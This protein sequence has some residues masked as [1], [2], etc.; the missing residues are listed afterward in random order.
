MKMVRVDDIVEYCDTNIAYLAAHRQGVACAQL[1][2][3]KE[4]VKENAVSATGA[5]RK[6]EIMISVN[7]I[8]DYCNFNISNSK[9]SGESLAAYYLGKVMEVAEE[10]AVDAELAERRTE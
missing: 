7:E 1:R 8:I 3:V 10:W 9:E 6:E 2:G 4:V 5:N